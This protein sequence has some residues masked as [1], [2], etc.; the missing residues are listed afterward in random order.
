MRIARVSLDGEIHYAVLHD[1]APDSGAPEDTIVALLASHPFGEI[2]PEGR[3]LPL[4]QV[5]LLAP[6]IPSKIIVVGKNYVDHAQEMGG[7]PP[8]SPL[9]SLK[10][11]T[12]VIGPEDPIVLPWQSERVDHEGE[13]A[14]VIGRMCKDVPRENAHDVILGYT[15]ANDVSARD[16]QSLDGQWVRAKEFDTFCPL[17]PWIETDVDID[18]AD[19][20]CEVN[21]TVQQSGN[22]AEMIHDIP[23]LISF[24]SSVMTLLP[25]DV[26]LTGTPAGVGPIVSGDRVS[27]TVKGIGTLSNPVVDYV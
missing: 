25:G 20:V 5:R 15:C 3:V 18:D 27:V 19:V 4:S 14:V 12:S 2:A 21:G 9:I 13:L 6:V 16:L 26:I 10:P 8:V 24:I 11:S 7:A 22:A 23:A 17:G 1:A